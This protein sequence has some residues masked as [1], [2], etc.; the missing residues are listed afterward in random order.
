MSRIIALLVTNLLLLAIFIFPPR[1]SPNSVKTQLVLASQRTV[2]HQISS[3]KPTISPSPSPSL[4]PKALAVPKLIIAS[5]P[6][7]S[8]SPQ[9][10]VRSFVMK[11]I[12]NYRVSKGLAALT[13]NS[14]ICEFANLRAQAISQNFNHDGFSK[15]FSKVVEN[16]AKNSDYNNVAS[17]WIN[18]A[19]HQANL[20]ADITM[21]CVGN[22]K[23]FY[24]FEGWKP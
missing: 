24:T 8:P 7:P 15:P 19:P 21:G 18:S 3:P 1:L 13:Q 6:K 20:L 23:D 22:Y 5:S 12:N 17:A 16:I 10:D 14:E 2:H 4:T 11:S 9:L